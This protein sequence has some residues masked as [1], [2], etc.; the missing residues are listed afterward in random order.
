MS[1]CLSA[2]V[3][4]LEAWIVYAPDSDDDKSGTRSAG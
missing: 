4:A 2:R 3:G 1:G